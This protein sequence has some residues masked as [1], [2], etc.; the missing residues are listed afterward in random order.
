MNEQDKQKIIDHYQKGQG[1]IQ[2]IARVYR[3]S[4]NEVL[5]VLGMNDLLEVE[6][7][8]DLIDPS[9]AGPGAQLEYSKKYN[10]NFTSD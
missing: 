3:Y 2:D 10:I 5:Q 4:V 1:S 9:E 6:S 8:G 7:Q